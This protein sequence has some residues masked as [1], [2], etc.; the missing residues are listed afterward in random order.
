MGIV[1]MQ[2]VFIIIVLELQRQFYE[3]PE[4][5]AGHPVPTAFYT[6]VGYVL[7]VE[8]CFMFCKH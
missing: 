5:R 2:T 4:H 8:I 7:A 6:Y 1:L 3:Y